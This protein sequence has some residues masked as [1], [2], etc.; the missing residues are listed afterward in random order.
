MLNF[1]I[2]IPIVWYIGI[3]HTPIYY[4]VSFASATV[5][6]S[7]IGFIIII[8]QYIQ[9]RAWTL[10][11]FYF[12]IF[13]YYFKSPAFAFSVPR[14]RIHSCG[15]RASSRPVQNF[16]HVRPYII[17]IIIF[18]FIKEWERER[19]KEYYNIHTYIQ[20]KYVHMHCT[21]INGRSRECVREYIL[22]I[23]INIHPI[24]L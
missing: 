17:I 4:K 16:A 21:I 19:R 23:Y 12:I 9:Q 14:A 15:L 7:V 11:G 6:N 13:H 10:N 20:Y 8:K 18:F 22:Y 2:I 5:E 3:R 24:V 1:F